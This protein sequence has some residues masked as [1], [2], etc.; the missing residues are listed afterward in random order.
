V[1]VFDCTYIHVLISFL[2]NRSSTAADSAGCNK[3]DFSNV[4]REGRK[5]V[6]S[7]K[8]EDDDDDDDDDIINDDNSNDAEENPRENRNSHS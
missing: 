6:R 1:V 5:R 7:E 2:R 8:D 3:S 4:K